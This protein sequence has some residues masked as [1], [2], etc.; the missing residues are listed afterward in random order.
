MTK[1]S[2]KVSIFLQKNFKTVLYRPIAKRFKKYSQMW[3]ST[4]NYEGKISPVC[5][6]RF[7]SCDRRIIHGLSAYTQNKKSYCYAKPDKKIKSGKQLILLLRHNT[8]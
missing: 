3:I 6:S 4:K 1:N 5:V 7:S 2:E 8:H